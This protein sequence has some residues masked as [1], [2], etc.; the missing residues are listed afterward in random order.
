MGSGMGPG[1]GGGTGINRN[2]RQGNPADFDFNRVFSAR[3]V[4]QRARILE[5]PEPGYTEAARRNDTN[6][7]V[8]LG[9]VFTASGQVT[10]I[11]VIH[12]L[13]DG[14]TELAIA[15][16]QRIKFTPALIYGRPVSMHIQ[17]AYN[18]NLY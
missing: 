5:K 15:A 8:V 14:L 11:K 6:G 12:G 16:A 9:V 1:N 4:D 3:D 18:F 10:D 13:P 7:T 2:P 17:V